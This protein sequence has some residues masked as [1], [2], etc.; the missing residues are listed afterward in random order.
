MFNQVIQVGRMATDVTLKYTPNGVA[1]AD[2][3]I[4]VQ[5]PFANAAGEKECDFFTVIAW[6]Q[7]A[8]YAANYLSKSRLV[9]VEGR[10]QNREY[11]GNDGQRKRI[12]EIV[13]NNVRGL[14]RPREDTEQAS[15]GSP[16]AETGFDDPFADS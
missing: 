12:T 13:A 16:T 7:S 6:R 1:V 5:R 3:R 10:L 2:F 11:D 4:A 15:T 14:D 9:L 8:E